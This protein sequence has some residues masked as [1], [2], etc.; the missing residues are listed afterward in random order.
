MG[1]VVVDR[2]VVVRLPQCCGATGARNASALKID[3]SAVVVYRKFLIFLLLF[4]VDM[5]VVVGN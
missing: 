4:A 1:M 2:V 3:D 5:A